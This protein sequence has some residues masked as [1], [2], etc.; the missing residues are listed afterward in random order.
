MSFP[1]DRPKTKYVIIPLLLGFFANCFG[2][3]VSSHQYSVFG[4]SNGNDNLSKSLQKLSFSDPSKCTNDYV[5]YEGPLHNRPT[6][7]IFSSHWNGSGDSCKK[8]ETCRSRVVCI[9]ILY[10]YTYLHTTY[11]QC[12]K[13]IEHVLELGAKVD[14]MQC[15]FDEI[16][17]LANKIWDFICMEIQT[18]TMLQHGPQL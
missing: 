5:M 15:A 3:F 13:N 14:G 9:A 17:G 8:N 4:Q 1:L 18:L 2:F 11:V 16:K 7:F 6:T 10:K 12:P